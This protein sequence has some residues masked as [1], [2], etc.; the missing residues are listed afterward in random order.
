MKKGQDVQNSWENRVIFFKRN[1]DLQAFVMVIICAKTTIILSTE[2]R[3]TGPKNGVYY[4]LT[5]K[6]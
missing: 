2:R 5:K 4:S 3:F 6:T 1:K